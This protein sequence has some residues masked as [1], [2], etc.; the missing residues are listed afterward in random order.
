MFGFL[1]SNHTDNF[2]NA[3][4]HIINKVITQTDA[5]IVVI[6]DVIPTI[7]LSTEQKLKTYQTTQEQLCIYQYIY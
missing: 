5:P 7:S 4:P 3:L 6:N 1:I 2:T